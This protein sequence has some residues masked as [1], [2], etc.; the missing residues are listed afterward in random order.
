M[1]ALIK[2]SLKPIQISL[3]QMNIV[4]D[5]F[6]KYLPDVQVWAFGSRAKWTAR[7][8]SDLDLALLC[9]SKINPKQLSQLRYALEESRLPFTV[10]ILE[11]SQIKPDFQRAIQADLCR[12]L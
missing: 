9:A 12:I 2:E 4:I 6:A 1:S 3:D 5:L 10:D 7:P 8:Y 11:W